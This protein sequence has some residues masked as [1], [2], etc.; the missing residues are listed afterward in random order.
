VDSL[1]VVESLSLSKKGL[2]EGA[3]KKRKSGESSDSPGGGGESS[4][5]VP[6]AWKN[7]KEHA[8]VFEE[9]AKAEDMRRKKR[10]KRRVVKNGYS[11][12]KY[13]QTLPK[14]TD[15]LMG[16]ANTHYMQKNYAESLKIL[17]EVVRQCPGA[18]DPWHTMGLIHEEEGRLEKAASCFYTAALNTHTDAMLFKNAGRLLVMCKKWQMASSCFNHALK[19]D[20]KDVNAAYD[21]AYCQS[22]GGHTKRAINTLEPIYL[23]EKS[24]EAGIRLSGCY[25]DYSKPF[26][27]FQIAKETLFKFWGRLCPHMK[28]LKK[29]GF[30]RFG[31]GAAEEESDEVPLTSLQARHREEGIKELGR[32][33]DAL[34]MVVGHCVKDGKY[35]VGIKYTDLC[36]Y[37]HHTVHNSERKRKGEPL[38]SL[39]EEPFLLPLELSVRHGL[40]K[41]AVGSTGEGMMRIARLYQTPREEAGKFA[42]IFEFVGNTF[43]ELGMPRR[44]M[45][46]FERLDTLSEYSQDVRILFM[47][48]DSYS[49]YNDYTKEAEMYSRLAAQALNLGPRDA[50]RL[51]RCAQFLRNKIE[52][53]KE[54]EPES[55]RAGIDA[56]ASSLDQ[57]LPDTEAMEVISGPR[58]T[59]SAP[60]PLKQLGHKMKRY[61]NTKQR[62][63]STKILKFMSDILDSFVAE[64]GKFTA[65]P[66]DML[67]TLLPPTVRA[68]IEYMHAPP[69][70]HRYDEVVKR[71]KGDMFF[72]KRTDLANDYLGGIRH[73]LPANYF[74]DGLAFARE[75]VCDSAARA[76]RGLVPA[77]VNG[78]FA[79]GSS[80]FLLKHKKEC[81]G[82]IYSFCTS[83]DG[84]AINRFGND[85]LN[86]AIHVLAKAAEQIKEYP[87]ALTCYEYLVTFSNMSNTSPLM[88]KSRRA[89]LLAFV[90]ARASGKAI[91]PCSK[92][93]YL[94]ARQ[95]LVNNTDLDKCLILNRFMYTSGIYKPFKRAIARMYGQTAKEAKEKGAALT[96]RE[97]F[98]LNALC[99][100]RAESMACSAIARRKAC[101]ITCERISENTE[102]ALLH[103]LGAVYGLQASLSNKMCDR[104]GVVLSTFA[105]FQVYMRAR[106]RVAPRTDSGQLPTSCVRETWYNLGRG[107]QDISLFYMAQPCYIR[108]ILGSEE[109]RTLKDLLCAIVTVKALKDANDP[110]YKDWEEPIVR[111]AAI[112]LSQIFFRSGSIALVEALSQAFLSF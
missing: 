83:S 2:L 32:D 60:R 92:T 100:M 68:M 57:W 86:R 55:E 75:T 22:Q 21:K 72:V 28:A 3:R 112:N 93:L 89:Y 12:Q 62:R 23:A 9:V 63:D 35:K 47:R 29:N 56:V 50:G 15:D 44:A 104:H 38:L 24:L 25:A 39:A 5:T 7:T 77:L 76:F 87:L 18:A 40:C 48:A 41:F 106:R 61:P 10:R 78:A 98:E 85:K 105:M 54:T 82:L 99:V 103:L 49:R 67:Y 110:K 107:Y 8:A 70:K 31:T 45:F 14:G 1:G 37:V 46:A 17:A 33:F 64:D 43:S 74:T 65:D 66:F 42:S 27:A 96:S 58:L 91:V 13:A 101:E 102:N 36:R 111:A 81:D 6:L 19:R 108:A 94:C 80:P 11:K 84:L 71:M 20:N 73:G 52:G 69:F 88:L 97:Q 34:N 95:F 4:G 59:P 30:H 26:K 53:M 90:S 51:R 16:K 79:P 109:K